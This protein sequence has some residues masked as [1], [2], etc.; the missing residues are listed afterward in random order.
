MRTV[1]VHVIAVLLVI[2]YTNMFVAWRFIGQQFGRGVVDALPF[3]VVGVAFVLI[4]VFLALQLR[5]GGMTIAWPWLV[6]AVAM[7]LVGLGSTDPIYAAKRIH[8]P[9]YALLGLVVW[10]SIKSA[11]QTPRTLFLVIL[12]GALYGVHDEFLQGIH[13]QRSF[14]IRDMLT[15]V[16]GVLAGVFFVRAIA[17][18]PTRKKPEAGIGKVDY[19]LVGIVSTVIVGVVLLAFA[20]VA[21]RFDLIPYWSVL[22]VLAAAVTVALW[23]ERQDEPGDRA[24]IRAISAIC[25]LFAIYPLVINVALLDFA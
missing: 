14:G 11:D 22:P 19:G 21:F 8:V 24:A 4:A 1:F 13:P 25:M 12:A 2:T 3:I 6:A 7:V 15:D 20:G 18:V 17:K 10:F 5:R 16:C 9:Q 23:A